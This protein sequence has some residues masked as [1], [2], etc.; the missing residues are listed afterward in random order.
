MKL[1][2]TRHAIERY[3]ERVR[4][5]LT[6]KQARAHLH[7]LANAADNPQGEPPFRVDG[8][9][10]G[11]MYLVIEF[12]VALVLRDRPGRGLAATTVVFNRAYRVRRGP[13]Q[14]QAAA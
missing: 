12:G 3:V 10:T 5:D 2:L 6:P 4:P 8:A 1:G 11:A 13:D 7:R 9:A 14:S